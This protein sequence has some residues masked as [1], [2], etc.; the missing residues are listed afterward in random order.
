MYGPAGGKLPT[1]RSNGS[2]IAIARIAVRLYVT[3][4]RHRHLRGI[5]IMASI[6]NI[7]CAVNRQL[8]T[9]SIDETLLYNTT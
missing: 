4:K 8:R 3:R 9:E 7:V 1:N 6:K 5:Q 2:G